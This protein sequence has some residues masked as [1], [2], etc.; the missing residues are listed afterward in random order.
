MK[1]KAIDFILIG[2]L[3]F[4]SWLLQPCRSRLKMVKVYT[5]RWCWANPFRPQAGGWHLTPTATATRK[6][7]ACAMTAV[8]S[9]N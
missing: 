1:N 8:K 6:S 9:P 5:C 2:G 3:R 4:S 7:T